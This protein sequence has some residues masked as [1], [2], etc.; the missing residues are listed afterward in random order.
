MGFLK[1]LFGSDRESQPNQQSESATSFDAITA[2]TTKGP[3]SS[4][5]EFPLLYLYFDDFEELLAAVKTGAIEVGLS[6]SM[7]SAGITIYRAFTNERAFMT[8]YR[9]GSI[10][11]RLPDRTWLNRDSEDGYLDE[12]LVQAIATCAPTSERRTAARSKERDEAI[13]KRSPGIAAVM[14]E[15]EDKME[16]TV[17]AIKV[18]Y[19]LPNSTATTPQDE[20]SMSEKIS[21]QEIQKFLASMNCPN[22]EPYRR[23]AVEAISFGN[24]TQ[25]QIDNVEAQG[26]L[27]PILKVLKSDGLHC[28]VCSALVR[29]DAETCPQCGKD[30]DRSVVSRPQRQKAS[31]TGYATD[32]IRYSGFTRAGWQNV[33]LM[34]SD[35]DVDLIR[36]KGL[37]VVP[38]GLLAAWVG[39][40]G[41]NGVCRPA[42]NLGIILT[43]IQKLNYCAFQA[44]CVYTMLDETDFFT[45]QGRR[46]KV[47]DG[48]KDGLAWLA[49]KVA[50]GSDEEADRRASEA[51]LVMDR[52]A[53]DWQRCVLSGQIPESA[54]VFEMALAISNAV[55]GQ[56]NIVLGTILLGGLMESARG[57][58]TGAE[59]SGPS[60]V[61]ES[62][63]YNPE[64]CT[65]PEAHSHGSDAQPTDIERMA[66]SRPL[67]W[68]DK[69][70]GHATDGIKYAGLTPAGWQNLRP[71]LS[72]AEVGLI[73]TK[74][75][76]VVPAGLLVASA[77]RAVITGVCKPTRE[78]GVIVLTPSQKL[79]YCAFEAFLLYNS[80]C[81]KNFFTRQGRRQEVLDG[82]RNDLAW[83]AAKV[84]LGSDVE[85]DRR[86]PE[87]ASVIDRLATAWERRVGKDENHRR[88]AL[89]E[90]A[91][92]I[93]DAVLGEATDMLGLKLLA[94]L[95]RM[96]D[97]SSAIADSLSSYFVLEPQILRREGITAST[98][99]V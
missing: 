58:S 54:A 11:L 93:A 73:R 49:A 16:P 90:M 78:D 95:L 59:T 2:K 48:W 66:I 82:W 17:Q 3:P 4:L 84:A 81:T 51:T 56:D 14:A 76:F 71:M 13:A 37:T 46:E 44:Y 55:L 8:L 41:I 98:D 19:G 15:L 29:E 72:D 57:I 74:R 87:A 24:K 67:R 92:V 60:F 53:A 26:V 68:N 27:V 31:D 6:S 94:R 65:I 36:T 38:A 35:A 32:G 63:M 75:L 64:D 5:R 40:R 86:A 96:E 42:T 70:P 83:M 39:R 52:L 28:A 99:P 43:P 12:A 62:G 9:G 20:V 89:R 21:E 30:F 23:A 25:E 33:K 34:L 80:M 18:R 47:L 7:R 88:D 91:R 1:K 79:N 77:G 85:A 22:E 10:S 45:R 61:I 50:L 97:S 69:D